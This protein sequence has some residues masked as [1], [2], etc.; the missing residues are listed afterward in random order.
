MRYLRVRLA[1]AEQFRHPMHES[2][3]AHEELW[4]WRSVGDLPTMLFRVVGP[5]RIAD[6]DSVA[7]YTLTP[8]TD[9]AFYVVVRAT[10]TLGEWD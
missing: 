2:L 9:E 3:V 7:E 5:E 4:T 1:F 8:V 10:P 6:V